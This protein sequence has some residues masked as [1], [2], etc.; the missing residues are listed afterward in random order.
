[1]KIKLQFYCLL[2]IFFI[3]VSCSFLSIDDKDSMRVKNSTLIDA[4]DY[5]ENNTSIIIGTVNSADVIE[6]PI[7]V[8]VCSVD[9]VKDAKNRLVSYVILNHTKEFMIYLPEGD[10][11][12]YAI[13]D[14]NNNYIF[15]DKEITGVYGKPD[16]ISLSQNEIKSGIIIQTGTTAIKEINFPEKLSIQYNYNSVEYTTYNGQVRK[17]YSEIFSPDNAK[18][19]WWH[20]SLFMKAFGT[21]IYLTEKYDPHRIPVIFIH[22]AQGSPYDWAHIYVHLDKKK[23][24]PLFFYYPSGLRLPMLSELLYFKIKDLEHTYKFKE[25]Y[26]AAHS[27]GGLVSRCMLTNYYNKKEN[28]IKYYVTFA[29]PWSGFEF[30]D[31]ALQT[32]PY[33]LPS[34]IDVSSHSMFIKTTLDK[35]LPP[36]VEYYLFFGKNDKTSKDKALDSRA[37]KDAKGIF[38]FNCDHNNILSDKDVFLKFN[39][40]LNK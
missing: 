6:Q 36:S 27:M 18:I 30:A 14:L 29:T 20:P 32:A 19:G 26:I 38:G 10:Y 17:I 25:I 23:F 4:R 37:Y 21:N 1:M 15:E 12:L 34:W 3:F 16:K 40:I 9:L 28:L 7:V 2:N 31:A 5:P 13:I 33:V 39:E 22:G 8:A 11:F 35:S 24:Q